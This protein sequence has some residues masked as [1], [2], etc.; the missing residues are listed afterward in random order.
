MIF[1]SLIRYLVVG[2]A[3]TCIGFGIIFGLMYIG[4]SPKISNFIVYF[5]GIII[6]LLLNKKYTFKNTTSSKRQE[7][8][9]FIFAMLFAY[10][11]NF[12]ALTVLIDIVEANVYLSQIISGGI[13][14]FT[15]FLLSYFVVFKKEYI[16]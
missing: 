5:F 13:Y 6:S 10:A 8:F 16:K 11:V 3:N 15:G 4:V 12:I 9:R 1:N 14:V 7:W 2:V